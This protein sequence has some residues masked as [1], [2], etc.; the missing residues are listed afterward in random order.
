MRTNTNELCGLVYTQSRTP[1]ITSDLWQKHPATLC[2]YCSVIFG[3]WVN[4]GF[5][6]IWSGLRKLNITYKKAL[7][8]PRAEAEK[9]RIFQ[10]KIE[11]HKKDGRPIVYIDESGFA[12]DM[13]RTHGYAIKGKRCFGT[14][15]WQARGRI[16]V[17]GA[18]LGTVLLTVGLFTGN[19]NSD[20]FNRWL[21]DNLIPKLPPAS[22]LVMDNA[23]FHKRSDTKK[24]IKQAGH[25][26]EY[27]PS[28]SPDYNPIE[29]KWAQA[30]ATK[31]RIQCTTE[32][33]FDGE[34][35]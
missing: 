22:V 34:F 16:N 33:L 6:S 29:K 15:D 14:H 28:Y 5:Q 17:I 35:I 1:L 13:P 9:R 12:H 7:K 8:H 27:L 4:R 10:E 3:R 11:K 26:L 32:E 24:S 25:F 21:V 30:K 31:R 19:I 23:T 2:F 20:L 18:L